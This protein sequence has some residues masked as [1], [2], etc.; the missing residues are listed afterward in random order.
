MRMKSLKIFEVQRKKNVL[1]LHRKKKGSLVFKN[2]SYGDQNP[3]SPTVR[4][5][6]VIS[7][8]E[9]AEIF[10]LI[11]MNFSVLSAMYTSSIVSVYHHP[12]LLHFCIFWRISVT[13][14]FEF[15]EYLFQ[16]PYSCFLNLHIVYILLYTWCIP[17]YTSLV[18]QKSIRFGTL[19]SCSS[20]ISPLWDLSIMSWL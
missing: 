8:L 6:H 5:S 3:K 7:W 4:L 19:A 20:K 1:I 13:F 11:F 12:F 2:F 14:F 10:G 17:I 18:P 15:P 9:F 16:N